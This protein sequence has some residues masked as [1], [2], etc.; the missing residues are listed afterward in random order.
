[1]DGVIPGTVLTSISSTCMQDQALGTRRLTYYHN[2]TT[3]SNNYHLHLST[4][5]HIHTSP[6]RTLTNASMREKPSKPR[7]FAMISILF[8]HLCRASSLQKASQK[9][10]SQMILVRHDAE[11]NQGAAGVVTP[12]KTELTCE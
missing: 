10:C 6:L 12:A 3:R 8:L 4:T 7:A 5:F 2:I 9:I 11:M 1:M